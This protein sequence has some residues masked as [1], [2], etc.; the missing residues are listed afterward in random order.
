MFES[1][2]GHQYFQWVRLFCAIVETRVATKWQPD[3]CDVLGVFFRLLDAFFDFCDQ[4]SVRLRNR[5]LNAVI[6]RAKD[7]KRYG[8]P[9][10]RRLMS[11]SQ[12]ISRPWL[13]V[14]SKGELTS[15]IPGQ[16][17]RALPILASCR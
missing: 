5:K 7:N 8:Q 10:V 3:F 17:R 13:H 1:R 9:A 6:G 2:R 12:W 15:E 4:R 14:S 16:S 11:G